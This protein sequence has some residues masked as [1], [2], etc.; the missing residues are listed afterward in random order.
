MNKIYSEQ[1]AKAERLVES[2]GK[3]AEVLRQKGI[4]IN[5]ARLT[6][7]CEALERAAHEQE[8]AELRLAETRNEAHKRLD[9][10]KTLFVESKT[11]IKQTFPPQQWEYFGLADKR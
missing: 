1:I 5:V 8:A 11:P 3:N 2:V 7:A 6:S 10:L 4:N 9:E